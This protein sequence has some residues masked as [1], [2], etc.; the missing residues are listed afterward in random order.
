M[1]IVLDIPDEFFADLAGPGQDLSRAAIEAL[2]LEAYRRRRISG[3]PLRMFLGIGSRH[4]FDGFLKR[5]EVEKHT[6]ADF[7]HDLRTISEAPC[8]FNTA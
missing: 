4:E 6:V 2:G 8:A 7:E 1:Q 3:F 5:H